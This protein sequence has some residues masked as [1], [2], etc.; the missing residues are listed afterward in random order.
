MPTSKEP[1]SNSGN[2]KQES[3]KNKG[4]KYSSDVTSDWIDGKNHKTQLSILHEYTKDGTTYIVDGH[5]VVLDHSNYEY[6][7]ANWL[8]IKTGLK[9]DILP[10][11][12]IPWNANTPDYLLGGVPFDL[13][14]ITGSGKSVIDGNLHKTKKQTPNIIFD[15]TKSPLSHEEIMDQMEQV[16][17]SGRR[18]LQTVII[19]DGHE[20][21]Y[22]LT[23]VK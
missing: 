11:V 10:R 4:L 17:R 21:L 8:S 14:E 19:K 16:Y 6:K 9:V 1:E 5:S 20:L 12:N 15:I 2:A 13:K 23:P 18:G 7:V 22:V 3:D